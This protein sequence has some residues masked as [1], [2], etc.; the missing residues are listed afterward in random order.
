M[1][2]SMKLIIGVFNSRLNMNSVVNYYCY[3]CIIIEIII[4]Y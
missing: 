3:N 1:M 2:L 4:N